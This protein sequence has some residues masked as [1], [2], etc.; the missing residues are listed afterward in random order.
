VA[1][2]LAVEDDVG[3]AVETGAVAVTVDDGDEGRAAVG[4]S[5]W[6]WRGR[7]V[8]IVWDLS[9]GRELMR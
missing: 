7:R 9:R 2:F 3:R 6:R 4:A 1:L 5:D 8:G